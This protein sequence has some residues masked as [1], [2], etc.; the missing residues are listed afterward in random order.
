MKK[1][2]VILLSGGL[3][4][5]TVSALALKQGVELT[6]ITV[7]Y[8][9]KHSRE[10]DS[11]IQIAQILKIKHEVV[12]ISFFKKL[13]WY[14]ALTNTDNFSIPHERPTEE[15]AKDIPITYVPLRN[16]FFITLAAAFVESQAL[17]LIEKNQIAPTQVRASIFIAAN[18]IDY[19]GYPDCRPEYYQQMSKALFLG[20]KLGTQYGQS[21]NLETP[22][23]SLSKAE[24]IKLAFSLKVPLVHTWSCY[25]G[26]EVPCGKCDSC[27]IR[28]AGFREAGYADPLLTG[29]TKEQD[30]AKGK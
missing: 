15:M 4:S 27:L 16:T 6:G 21:I 12:D 5:T 30:H 13:A 14:S 25:E 24:I 26:G 11:A 28:A 10:I 23:I 18:A 3:D 20:S 7:R 1:I 9:Q 17:N 22:I 8:G 2:G 19:S 29:L